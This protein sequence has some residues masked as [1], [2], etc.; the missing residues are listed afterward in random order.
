[1]SDALPPII[2]EIAIDAPIAHVWDAMTS[3]ATV[4]D[5]LGCMSYRR[6]LG[7]VFYMQQDPARRG[8]GDITGA[9]HCRVDLL[10]EP[11]RFTFA[12]F[13]PGTPETKVTISLAAD[14]PRRTL[15]RLAHEG[16][17][18][19]PAE[20]VKPFHDQLKSGWSSGALPSLKAAAERNS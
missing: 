15:V 9:T 13:V 18:Q 17:D 16:W 3:E 11:N 1:M 10:D 2:A 4:P 20:M 14:G 6:A 7:A 5:W 8:Q 19:F 12:W